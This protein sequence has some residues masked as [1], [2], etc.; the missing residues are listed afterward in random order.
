ML[1][2][3]DEAMAGVREALTHAPG[4]LERW[5]VESQLA[6]MELRRD[7]VL[8]L[9]KAVLGAGFHDPEGLMLHVREL[10]H[11]G[12][13]AEATALL[14]RVIQGGYHCPAALTRDPWLD[15]LRASPEFVRLVRQ[16]EAGHA[17]AAEA[18][19]AGGRRADPRRRGGLRPLRLPR[20]GGA[21]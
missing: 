18:V 21:R 6:A 9:E 4:N 7:D 8:R 17:R 14:E 16:A 2:R 1:G 13:V 3:Q 15:S 11:V 19:P 20:R 5:I 12:A 10:A